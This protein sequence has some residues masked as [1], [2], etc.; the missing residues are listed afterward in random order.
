MVAMAGRKKH[1]NGPESFPRARY[2]MTGVTPVLR[3]SLT[4][5]SG[6]GWGAWSR[7]GSRSG[8]A[9]MRTPATAI[10]VRGLVM[11]ASRPHRAVR[12]AMVRLV[13]TDQADRVRATRSLS[14]WLS[15]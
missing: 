11:L 1:R 3:D 13:L 5:G 2:P 12:A 10:A 7:L 9:K 14:V 6:S 15:R 4:A 8:V